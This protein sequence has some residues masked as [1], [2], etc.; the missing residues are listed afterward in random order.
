VPSAGAGAGACGCLA[1]RSGG[2]GIGVNK[3]FHQPRLQCV[4]TTDCTRMKTQWIDQAVRDR[5]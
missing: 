2:H 1:H 4:S 5:T 3:T